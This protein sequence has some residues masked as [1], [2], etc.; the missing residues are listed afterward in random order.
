M[1]ALVL[2][3]AMIGCTAPPSATPMP[4]VNA[5]QP[6]AKPIQPIAATKLFPLSPRQGAFAVRENGKPPRTVPFQLQKHGDYWILSDPQNRT[7]L[8]QADNGDLVIFREDDA[9]QQVRIDYD[10]AIVML[11]A[12]IT[13]TSR[14]HGQVKMIVHNLSN[15]KVRDQGT[16]DYT[17]APIG[18]VR[19]K[20]PAG[21]YETYHLRTTRKINLHL[22]NAEV[23]LDTSYAPGVGQVAQV[24]K[25][26]TQAL[27]LFGSDSTQQSL[28]VR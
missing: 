6:N 2:P 4:G 14:P 25:Q 10:P 20:T 19:V 12:R 9:R 27:G 8:R 17:I 18:Q 11:P 26:H 13:P 5:T 1:L 28:R 23:T 15:G 22:A 21:V 3:L 24:V 7:Y 16:C